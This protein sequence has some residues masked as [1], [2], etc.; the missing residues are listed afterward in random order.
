MKKFKAA[1][2]GPPILGKRGTVQKA[3]QKAQKQ[4]SPYSTEKGKLRN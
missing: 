4:N 1:I 2:T 3:V